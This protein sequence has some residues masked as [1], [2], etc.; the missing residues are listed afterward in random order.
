MKPAIFGLFGC[1]SL[2]LLAVGF[3]FIMNEAQPDNSK[4]GL[5]ERSGGNVRKKTDIFSRLQEKDDSY[6]PPETGTRDE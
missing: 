6:N 3:F 5:M 2:F 4:Q 1:V